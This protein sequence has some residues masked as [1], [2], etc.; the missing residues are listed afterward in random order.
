MFQL[1]YK[2]IITILYSIFVLLIRPNVNILVN[3]LLLLNS[4]DMLFQ[5]F[6]YK[7]FQHDFESG[8]VS[9]QS[10]MSQILA[11][12]HLSHPYKIKGTSKTHLHMISKH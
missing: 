1:M 5:N 4:P 9:R 12:K 6:L 3:Y 11:L 8:D 7:L 10:L 2:K